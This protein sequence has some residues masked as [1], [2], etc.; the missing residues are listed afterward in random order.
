V[1]QWIFW[2]EFSASSALGSNVSRETTEC[3]YKPEWFKTLWILT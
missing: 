1:P 3:R 2:T